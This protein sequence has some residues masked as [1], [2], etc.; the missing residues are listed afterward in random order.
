MSWSCSQEI[1]SAHFSPLPSTEQQFA[2]LFA[3]G[4]IGLLERCEQIAWR[5]MSRCSACAE[6]M[7][8]HLAECRDIQDIGK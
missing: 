1:R 6:A 7:K 2:R 3:A 8:L 5:I 4:Q